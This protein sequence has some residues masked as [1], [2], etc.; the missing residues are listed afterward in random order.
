MLMIQDLNHKI[1]KYL[2]V[3]KSLEELKEELRVI[4]EKQTKLNDY[5][6]FTKHDIIK[7]RVRPGKER[8]SILKEE[9]EL[10]KL[11]LAAFQQDFVR[12]H[13]VEDDQRYAIL[14]GMVQEQN[15]MNLKMQSLLGILDQVVNLQENQNSIEAWINKAKDSADYIRELQIRM[16]C[17]TS[18]ERLD[19]LQEIKAIKDFEY[20]LFKNRTPFE[21][22][23]KSAI[24]GKSNFLIDSIRKVEKLQDEKLQNYILLLCNQRSPVSGSFP[25]VLQ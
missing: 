24:Q 1:L 9:Q 6:E 19:S 8:I 22:E 10:F 11:N 12:I 25:N 17:F 2:P 14:W 20:T 13:Q 4:T 18:Q 3:K 15:S 5:L 16:K 7:N 21:R 23:L